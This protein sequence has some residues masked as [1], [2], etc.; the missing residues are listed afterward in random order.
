MWR[1]L[2]VSHE[3][4]WRLFVRDVSAQYRQSLLGVAWAF[5]P[6]ILTGLVFVVLQAK[7]VIAFAP[8]DIP[9]PVFVFIGTVYWQVFVDA[10]NA[11]LKSVTAAR[12]IIARINFPREAL[13]LSAAYSVVFN[14]AIRGIVLVGVFVYF[15]VSATLGLL[16]A[17]GAVAFLILLGLAIGLA[18]TPLGMLYTD[19]SS[20]L[21]A[22]T[23]VWFFATPVVYPAPEAFPLSLLATANPVSPLLT[24]ARDLTATG[25]LTNPT[26]FFVTCGFTL[27]GIF[28]AWTLYRVALPILTERMSA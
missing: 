15:D 24:A 27:V 26:A 23:Q 18:L 1:N 3:L 25:T 13:I 17:P 4:A 28:V 9:Y 20:G 14:A 22:F 2:G 8:T 19:V 21:I 12:P 7:S 10:L 5:L 6:P 16:L 11:P